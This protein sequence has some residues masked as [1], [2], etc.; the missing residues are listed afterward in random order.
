MRV[1]SCMRTIKSGIRS[2]R[3]F[4]IVETVVAM[5]IILMLTSAGIAACTVALKIQNNAIN[6]EQVYNICDE[7]VSAFYDSSDQNGFNARLAFAVGCSV[8]EYS[9]GSENAVITYTVSESSAVYTYSAS[10][11]NVEATLTLN[12]SALESITVKGTATGVNKAVFD[13]TF[14]AYGAEVESD[15]Q[16]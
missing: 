14:S 3:G 8:G 9:E 4:S 6:S 13:K 16:T 2:R 7:F 10:G 5:A 12:G 1:N 15:E 11:M